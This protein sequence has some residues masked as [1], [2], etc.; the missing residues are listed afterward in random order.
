MSHDQ[1]ELLYK[2]TDKSKKGPLRTKNVILQGYSTVILCAAISL[3]AFLSLSFT[4]L[5][6]R[7][8][9]AHVSMSKCG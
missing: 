6:S 4:V 7:L 1:K 2:I 8:I 3:I 9:Q 5:T